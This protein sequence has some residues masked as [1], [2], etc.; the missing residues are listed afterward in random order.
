MRKYLIPAL[1]ILSAAVVGFFVLRY[2]PFEGGRVYSPWLGFLGGGLAGFLILL[3]ERAIRR[4]PFLQILGGAIGLLLG[5][6]LARLLSSFFQVFTR[7]PWTAFLY[8]ML[9]LGLGYLGLVVG[10]RRFRELRLPEGLTHPFS[11][12]SK[13]FPRRECPKVVDTSAIIDGR[14]ADICE[15]GWVEGPLIIPNFVLQELQQ[16][17]DSREHAR[18]E[19]GRRGLDHLRRIQESGKVEVRFIDQDYPRLRDID[20]KLVRLCRE[21][22][23]KLITTDYN[24]NK[25]ARLKGV[26]VLNVNEL[27]LALRPVVTPG[28]ELRVEII[29]EGKERHQGVGY[30]SDGT[31]VV[32][33]GGREFIGQEVEVVVTSLLQTPSGRIVFAQPKARARVA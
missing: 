25:V 15:T 6:A 27:A 9:A 5:L 26:E 23:A 30:L 28:E 21:L 16:V 24:L 20:A 4:L 14:L 29:K 17:A 18:R 19:R 32:V 2:F 31:M 33:E 12:V 13:K 1:L 10:G 3:L 11:Y 22:S 8:T 7:G